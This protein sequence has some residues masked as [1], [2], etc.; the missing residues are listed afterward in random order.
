L[1]YLEN[2]FAAMISYGLTAELL[3][4][5]H[6]RAL[7]EEGCALALAGRRDVAVQMWS[8]V[9][10]SS[11]APPFESALAAN[12]LG[13]VR[14]QDGSNDLAIPAYTR[15]IDL[16]HRAP[17]LRAEVLINRGVAHHQ[18]GQMEA[19]LEDFSRAIKTWEDQPPAVPRDLVA[20]A[21][22]Y[23]GLTHRRK[24]N[25]NLAQDDFS[26]ALA[27]K[28][29]PVDCTA[30]LACLAAPGVPRAQVSFRFSFD[31]PQVTR[32]QNGFPSNF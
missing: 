31:S 6:A 20:R 2:K 30:L 11:D 22:V 19:A 23:R 18:S 3:A 24:G 12:Y 28:D 27:L 29:V 25:T 32:T 1:A 16:D 8:R 15:A 14:A 10:E 21:L 5:A 26:R 13:V 4:E 7:L 17:G 9:L